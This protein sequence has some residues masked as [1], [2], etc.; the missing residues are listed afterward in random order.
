MTASS[1][2]FE[3]LEK[4]HYPFKRYPA[5]QCD[6]ILFP[7]CA[8]PSQFSQTTDELGKI[9]REHGV[10]IA[11]DCCGTSL[12]QGAS[13]KDANRVLASIEKRLQICG[14]KRIAC[15]CPNCFFY[16]RNRL[17][18]E[19]ISVYQL[20][21]ELGIKNKGHFEDALLFVPCPDREERIF[22]QEIRKLCALE[23]TQSIQGGCCGLRPDIAA[24]GPDVSKKCAAAVAKQAKGW[25]LYSYCAS[26]SG[27]FERLGFTGFKHV[28]PE[29]LGIDEQPD[30]AH[31]FINRAK[32]K[33][34]KKVDPFKS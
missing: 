5:A 13:D 29:F 18:V 16:F 9:V 6:T 22:E 30:A 17:D 34:D 3:R 21:W 25:V 12:L 15:I 10:G 20:L 11:Y 14:C 27:Q 8:F 2:S 19:V 33:F 31:S 26:C 24:K 23:D 4:A 28:L 1:F 32:R 7:G